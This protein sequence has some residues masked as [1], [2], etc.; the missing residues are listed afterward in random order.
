M[1]NG[2]ALENGRILDFFVRGA[3]EGEGGISPSYPA[4]FLTHLFQD[5]AVPGVAEA[6]LPVT[7]ALKK[8]T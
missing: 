8:A 1:Q 6:S 4:V 2:R 7:T 3:T 5:L